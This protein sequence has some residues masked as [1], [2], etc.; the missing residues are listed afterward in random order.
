MTPTGSD[1]SD[2][3]RAGHGWAATS[4]LRAANELREALGRHSQL[5]PVADAGAEFFLQL[6]TART[7]TVT[8]LM[9]GVYC[10]LVI[11]GELPPGEVRYPA[12]AVFAE[13][14]YPESTRLLRERGGYLTSDPQDPVSV[15]YAVSS[16]SLGFTSLM[17]VAI[18]QA[19]E[20]RG[21]VCLTRGPNQ[22]AFTDDDFSLVRD[23]ATSFGARL[24]TATR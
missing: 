7:V 15:E 20:V 12:D 18:V 6:M 1:V 3:Y 5:T 16:V 22:P 21:E 2:R 8:V 13:E 10:D 19:G 24:V 14:L 4:R 17:G 23:L 9:D 11:A